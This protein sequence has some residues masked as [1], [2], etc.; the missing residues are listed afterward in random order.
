MYLDFL[1][2]LAEANQ[3]VSVATGDAAA[4]TTTTTASPAA[5]AFGSATSP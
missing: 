5:T 3:S 1:N 2:L 4:A